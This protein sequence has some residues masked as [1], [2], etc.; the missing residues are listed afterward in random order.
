MATDEPGP[1][2]PGVDEDESPFDTLSWSSK[3]ERDIVAFRG[4]RCDSEVAEE[5]DVILCPSA[6]AISFKVL[7]FA[8][9]PDDTRA[10]A[11]D[12][13]TAL[14]PTSRIT[15]TDSLVI[16]HR[17]WFFLGEKCMYVGNS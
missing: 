10:V 11:R 4:R 14:L 12:Y 15:I 2:L 9:S 16:N 7:T 1:D 17:N 6:W 13:V 3:L 8:I 5:E